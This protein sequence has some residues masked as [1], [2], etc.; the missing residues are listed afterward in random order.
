MIFITSYPFQLTWNIAGKKG[1]VQI[2]HSHCG[3]TAYPN[4]WHALAF[5]FDSRAQMFQVS[6]KGFDSPVLFVCTKKLLSCEEV[7]PFT[8][9]QFKCLE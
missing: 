4:I 7:K 3:G 6:R 5:T 1:K 2:N 8:F 9:K